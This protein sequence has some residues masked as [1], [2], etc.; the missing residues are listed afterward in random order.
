MLRNGD[1]SN[2]LNGVVA[3]VDVKSSL[4][5]QALAISSRLKYLGAEVVHS[6]T[7]SITHVI[8]RNGSE[9]TKQ[10]ARK[11]RVWLV[12]P[13]WIKACHT[14]NVRVGEAAYAC[15]EDYSICLNDS[16]ETS[17]SPKQADFALPP[18]N[19]VKRVRTSLKLPSLDIPKHVHQFFQRIERRKQ[20]CPTGVD[21]FSS[22]ES[23]GGEENIKTE[24][25]PA[26]FSL[27]RS[28]HRSTADIKPVVGEQL[29]LPVVS[30]HKISFSTGVL[31]ELQNKCAHIPLDE[32]A[33]T[34]GGG[35]TPDSPVFESTLHTARHLTPLNPPYPASKLLTPVARCNS[36]LIPRFKMVPNNHTLPATRKRLS[37]GT[38]LTPEALV[39]WVNAKKKPTVRSSVKAPVTPVIHKGEPKRKRR[40]QVIRVVARMPSASRRQDVNKPSKEEQ[41]ASTD[42]ETFES[43]ASSSKQPVCQT[44]E[45]TSEC[46]KLA[47]RISVNKC[48]KTDTCKLGVACRLR[49]SIP[50]DMDTSSGVADSE[51]I[52]SRETHTRTLNGKSS[53]KGLLGIKPLTNRN[54][55]E[56]F[57]LRRVR[58]ASAVSQC[59]YLIATQP[60]NEH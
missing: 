24:V 12:S 29:S 38:P 28:T 8:F 16:I 39:E 34:V 7:N 21:V 10:W 23:S 48:N 22:S 43:D 47:Q 59:C 45:K 40:K 5:N 51:P 18:N 55:L 49:K 17:Q 42:E 50:V 9:L 32:G 37:P 20:Q 44:S 56:D 25:D 6:L 53:T 58:R 26:R 2:I 35:T 13:L 36:P 11:R 14:H 52:A 19:L 30:L 46:G 1:H 33:T 57:K 54:S 15:R 41:A 31:T 4:G 3:F 60:I 27:T